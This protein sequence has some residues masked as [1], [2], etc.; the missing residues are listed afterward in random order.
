MARRSVR[1]LGSPRAR[2]LA[3]ESVGDHP[4]IL[5][6]DE[7]PVDELPLDAHRLT[8]EAHRSKRLAES[9]E[10]ALARGQDQT[11]RPRLRARRDVARCIRRRPSCKRSPNHGLRGSCES[12]ERPCLL[13]RS[14]QSVGTLTEGARSDD[15]LEFV[16]ELEGVGGSVAWIEALRGETPPPPPRQPRAP[17][18]MFRDGARISPFDPS[19]PPLIDTLAPR[20]PISCCRR[21]RVLQ[22]PISGAA[23]R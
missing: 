2:S 8:P 12:A 10:R 5:R 21:S 7:R 16:R 11:C 19:R 15:G 23:R 14:G 1:R 18:S 22:V 13:L 17:E 6:I 20:P 4:G 3:L 9:A